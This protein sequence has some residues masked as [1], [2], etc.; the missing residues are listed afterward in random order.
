[1]K[2]FNLSLYYTIQNGE[3]FG[4]V[5]GAPLSKKDRNKRRKL[6]ENKDIALVSLKRMV[7]KNKV[8]KM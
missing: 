2:V 6:D 3:H 1:M 8:E 5:N 7:E 4:D